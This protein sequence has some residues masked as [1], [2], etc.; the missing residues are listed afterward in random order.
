MAGDTKTFKSAV[1]A[2][3]AAWTLASAPTTDIV[4]E[5]GPVK[6]EQ[7]ISSPW[8]DMEVRFYGGRP[9]TT[10]DR[11]MGR[12]TGAVALSVYTRQGDGTGDADTL[13]DSLIERFRTRYL[14]G[15][16]LA[17]PQRMTPTTLKGWHK[18]GVL[19]PFTLDTN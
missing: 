11:P 1:A 15:G 2:E 18:V 16:S 10:G 12:H 8:V 3:L 9:A 4:Y 7:E 14:G 6:G 17:F 13:V 19:I 5:N